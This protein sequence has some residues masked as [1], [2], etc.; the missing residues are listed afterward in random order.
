[1][2]CHAC[3]LQ[4]ELAV[5]C[6]RYCTLLN[7]E[8]LGRR[9]TA[10]EALHTASLHFL[11]GRKVCSSPLAQQQ[12]HVHLGH[13]AGCGSV[14][15]PAWHLWLSAIA[16]QARLEACYRD[17]CL[18]AQTLLAEQ[19][20]GC[21]RRVVN[22]LA[23]RQ[24]CASPTLWGECSACGAQAWRRTRAHTRVA[25]VLVQGCHQAGATQKLCLVSQRAPPGAR[26]KVVRR[27][28]TPDS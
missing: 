14:S 20:G 5:A 11:L 12:A 17:E 1:M 22:L 23:V 24:R 3:A 19:G 18:G 9:Q 16:W 21:D 15:L 7:S 2:H 13:V 8:R 27:V 26:R 6:C 25:G 4:A 28:R 10:L